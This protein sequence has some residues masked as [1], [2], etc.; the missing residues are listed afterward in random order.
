MMSEL[1]VIGLMFFVLLLAACSKN[2]DS[3]EEIQPVINVYVYSPDH[4]VVTR[5]DI[6][7][8]DPIEKESL[9]NSLQ[10]WVFEHGTENLVSYYQPETVSNLND[11]K[12][13]TYQL[14]VSEAFAKADPK[15]T[16][17]VY[18]VANVKSENCG[19]SYGEETTRATLEEAKIGSSYFGLS[20]LV[21][22]VPGAGLP[23]SGV[24]RD[25]AVTGSAP[26]F[27]ISSVKLTRAV[28]KL[29]FIFSRDKSGEVVKI[30]SIKL[31]V[32]L[33]SENQETQISQIP[34]EEYLF[35]KADNSLYHIGSIYENGVTELLPS[36]SPLRN[37]INSND[38]PLKY[39]YQSGQNAQDYEN[40]IAAGVSDGKLSG[41]GPYY[42]RET[43]KQLS[44]VISYKKGISEDV[45][46]AEFKMKAAG[47]FSRNH[48]W[49]IY[50]YYGVDGMKVVTV[51]SQNWT[52]V[53]SESH[54]VYNW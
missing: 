41:V 32:E 48:T 22:A 54:D 31:G 46:K 6:G 14:N 5:G 1:R 49:I 43:D 15:P 18:V 40:L 52:E 10:I 21:A 28:S 29:C 25:V 47:D 53:S 7:N 12:G 4:P 20:S 24:L 13:V 23:M 17:D 11:D 16:V 34:T 30:S 9:I 2:E 33:G 51:Y 36:D 19:L 50:A 8:V 42:L 38:D 3:P 27:K 35:L 44:G 37:D 39:T 45:Y 26:V